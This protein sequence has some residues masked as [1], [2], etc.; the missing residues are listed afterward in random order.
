MSVHGCAESLVSSIGVEVS[1]VGENV[2]RKNGVESIAEM[3]GLSS[4][5]ISNS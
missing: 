2:S 5:V 3:S 4:Y 1:K